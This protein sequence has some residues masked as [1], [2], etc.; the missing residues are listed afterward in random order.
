VAQTAADE[1][2][3]FIEASVVPGHL[4]LDEADVLVGGGLCHRVQ[5]GQFAFH[6]V[7]QAQLET[8][9]IVVDAH[10]VP[11]VFPVLGLDVLALERACHRRALARLHGCDY[12]EAVA[13]L[14]MPAG[15]SEDHEGK[16]RARTTR[17]RRGDPRR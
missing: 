4:R 8:D 6:A 17:R 16:R 12:T 5:L 13:D 10:P 7:E 14:L 11:R 3:G 1:D 15:V 9:E 2:I